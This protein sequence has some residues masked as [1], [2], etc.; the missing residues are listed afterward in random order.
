MPRP[1][2]F[3]IITANPVCTVYKPAGVPARDIEWITLELDEFESIRL[4]DHQG[5]DQEH[6]ARIMGVSRPT[7]TRIYSRARQKI[8]SALV[9]GHAIRIIGLSNMQPQSPPQEVYGNRRGCGRG[10]GRMR[11]SIDKDPL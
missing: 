9:N 4:L 1:C 11:H 8:A 6:A 3:R 5:H 2:K 7:I 10:F